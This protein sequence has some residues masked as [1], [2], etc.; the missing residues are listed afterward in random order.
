MHD[1]QAV[2]CS[3]SSSLKIPSICI[4]KWKGFSFLYFRFAPRDGIAAILTPLCFHWKIPYVMPIACGLLREMYSV[5]AVVAGTVVFYFL[6]G[7]K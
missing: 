6:N 7:N 5:V 3:K 2:F 4:G 1:I